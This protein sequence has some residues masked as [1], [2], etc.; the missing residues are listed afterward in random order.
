MPILEAF[1]PS[2]RPMP[3]PASRGSLSSAARKLGSVPM[4]SLEWN[5][6][7]ARETA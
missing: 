4:P 2:I 5:E 6:S 3:P 7:V 1:G